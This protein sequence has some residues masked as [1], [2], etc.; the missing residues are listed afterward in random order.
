MTISLSSSAAAQPGLNSHERLRE[1]LADDIAEIRDAA[2]LSRVL[3]FAAAMRKQLGEYPQLAVP[4]YL[5]GLEDELRQMQTLQDPAQMRRMLD[6]ALR[7]LMV[8][9]LLT[10][11]QYAAQAKALHS[12]SAVENRRQSREALPTMDAMVMLAADPRRPAQHQRAAL[13]AAAAL[14][15]HFSAERPDEGPAQVPILGRNLVP[16]EHCDD[17]AQ[18]DADTHLLL[19]VEGVAYLVGV[20]ARAPQAEPGDLVAQF[21]WAQADARTPVARVGAGVVPPLVSA[22]T[23]QTCWRIRRL[24]AED[25]ANARQLGRIDRCL[26]AVCLDAPIEAEYA[27][28]I[29]R[30]EALCRRLFGQS[31][32]RWFGMTMIVVDEHADAAVIGGYTRGH[33]AV[34]IMA[35]CEH[36]VRM[37]QQMELPE[38]PQVATLSA[39]MRIE[40]I[41]FNVADLGDLGHA[42]RT[43]V[44]VA[45]HPRRAFYDLDAGSDFFKMLGLH[46]NTALQ[47]LLMLAAHEVHGG[48]TLPALSHAVSTHNGA[49]LKGGLDWVQLSTA[50]VAEILEAALVDDGG[51]SMLGHFRR[52]VRRHSAKVDAARQGYSP[53]SFIRKPGDA[54]DQLLFELF[55]DLGAGYATEYRSYL[56][57]PTRWPDTMDILTSTLRLPDHVLYCGRPGATNQLVTLFG[58]HIVL[59]RQRTSLFFIPN[60]ARTA[61]P[62]LVHAALRRWVERLTFA[63][64]PRA[65]CP[66]EAPT[67]LGAGERSA[68]DGVGPPPQAIVMRDGRSE[69]DAAG[70]HAHGR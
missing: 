9:Q 68:C 65:Q 13:L 12:G 50:G 10:P 40:H 56:F 29:D 21:L 1:W 33:E 31:G 59:H 55:R 22:A 20:G 17:V 53:S 7:R 45:F 41:A 67:M 66:E 60:P 30:L 32:N 58:L 16:G 63:A 39:T 19:L 42:A 14:R 48:A 54:L 36:I 28:D 51:V 11:E 46:P 35:Y 37:T 43:E 70:G 5:D 69:P 52:A 26:F 15:T 47:Y 4:P 23:R 62:Q 44:Q 64:T 38:V 18:E 25:A 34:P 61:L 49:R 57:R 27:P 24:L 8:G 6:D 2:A 3:E